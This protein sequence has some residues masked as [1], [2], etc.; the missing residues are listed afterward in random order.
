MDNL[1]EYSADFF[2]EL[3]TQRLSSSDIHLDLEAPWVS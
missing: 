1:S 3:V 2:A